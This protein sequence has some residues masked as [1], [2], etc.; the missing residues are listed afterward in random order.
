MIDQ[1]LSASAFAPG[2][3][4]IDGSVIDR[5]TYDKAF[6]RNAGLISDETQQK[7]RETKIAIPGMGGVG[8]VHLITLARL[9]V[10][11]F[12]IA[13]GDTFDVANFNRQY[14]ADVES[15]DKCKA[16]TMAAK[17]KAINPQL[18]LSVFDSLVTPDN[19]DEFLSGAQFLIDGVDFFSIE[20]RRMIF[21]EARRRGIWA[22]TAGPVGFSTAWLV[23]DPNGM[24]FDEYFDIHDGMSKEDQLIAFAVGLCPKATQSSYIDISK[25]DLNSGAAPSVGLACQLAS[26][27]AASEIVKIVSGSGKTRCVPKFQQF[28]LHRMKFAKGK[29]PQGNRGWIQKAKRYALKSICKR[30]GVLADSSN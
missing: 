4:V 14:G 17:V 16:L 6:G 21:Q 24:S 26:A 13:D 22:I 10:G 25:V 23:F 20:A 12:S 15:I 19:V 8:G 11:G 7:L 29:L 18:D 2:P 3:A 1:Q 5:W 27:A 28:D 9:G 30:N